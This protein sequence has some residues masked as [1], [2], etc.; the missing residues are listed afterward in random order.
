MIQEQDDE[1]SLTLP[2]EPVYVDGDKM[3]LAQAVSNLLNNAVKYSERGNTIWLSLK[4]EGGKAVIRVKDK[5]QGIPAHLLSK[6]FDMFI[7]G[8]RSLEKGQG[9][10]GVGLGIV[11][12]LVE[13]H[14]GRVEAHSEG[15]GLGSEFIIRLPV[16]SAPAPEEPSNDK[17]QKPVKASRHRILVVDDNVDAARLLGMLLKMLGHE[18]R[19]AHDGLEGVKAAEVFRPDVILLDLGMPKLNGY[20]ACRRIR[21]HSWGQ[22]MFIVALTGWGQE[23]D[24]TRSREAGFDHHLVKPVEREILEN[25]FADVKA[26]TV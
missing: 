8:D 10:L 11:K 9:G 3:R 19:I 13:M 12:Q 26:K 20:D 7:Q 16:A 6:V 21:E 2:E 14:Q 22:G 15:P 5:G 17:H 1:V 25:L 18:T 4:R 24:K 23:E